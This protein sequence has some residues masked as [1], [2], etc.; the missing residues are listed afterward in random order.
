ML[1]ITCC[2]VVFISKLCAWDGSR[3]I[4]DLVPLKSDV[5]YCGTD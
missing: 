3:H 5:Y 4:L 2:K 1:N